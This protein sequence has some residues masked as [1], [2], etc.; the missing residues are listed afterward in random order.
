MWHLWPQYQVMRLGWGCVILQHLV[1]FGRECVEWLEDV[2]LKTTEPVPAWV[3][4]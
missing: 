4:K 3:P 2:V 1:N